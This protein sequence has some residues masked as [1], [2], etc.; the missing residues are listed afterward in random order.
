MGKTP[1][2]LFVPAHRVIGAD[3]NVKG[4][5]PGSLRLQLLNFERPTAWSR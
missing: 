5:L 3:G 2:D 4:A 1:L